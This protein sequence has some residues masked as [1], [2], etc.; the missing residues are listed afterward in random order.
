LRLR[1][2]RDSRG[3]ERREQRRRR[4]R[5]TGPAATIPRA[6]ESVAEEEWKTKCTL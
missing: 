6:I 1:A 4:R 2:T 3:W 5:T